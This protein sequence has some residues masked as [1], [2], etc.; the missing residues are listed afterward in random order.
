MYF[1]WQH[2]K[3]TQGW[4]FLNQ[5]YLSQTRPCWTPPAGIAFIVK[6]LWNNLCVG[7]AMWFGVNYIITLNFNVLKCKMRLIII[8][9]IKENEISSQA[10]GS[11]ASWGGRVVGKCEGG[12]RSPVGQWADPSPCSKVMGAF[13][14]LPQPCILMIFLAWRNSKDSWKM[15]SSSTQ[16]WH[17]YI[18]LVKPNVYD[19]P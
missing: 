19:K 15:V 14:L 13:R 18:C 3:E 5:I 7:L 9:R 12:F 6:S 2:W 16:I 17:E 8:V 1:I 10:V 11:M 4:S